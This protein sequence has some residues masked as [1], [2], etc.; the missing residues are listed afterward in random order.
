MID[1][2]THILPSVDDGSQS[3]EMSVAMIKRLEEQGVEKIV[4]TPHFYAAQN[5]VDEFLQKRQ[6]AFLCLK[7]SLIEKPKCEIYMGAEVFYMDSLD[8]AEGFERLCVEGSE[9]LL[10]ELPFEKWSERVFET[11]F[12]ITNREITP[13]IAHF[14]RFLPFGNTFD[15]MRSLRGM[16]CVLQM[17]ANFFDGMFIRRKAV[18]FFKEGIAAVLGSDCHNMTT[19]PPEIK[20][21]YDA[22]EKSLGKDMVR[23]MNQTGEH[24]LRNAR[25]YI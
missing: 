8:K 2:H 16:G 5:S 24:I 1:M 12:R 13:I 15:D 10:L 19:R 21:A 20:S 18:K 9:F 7:N 4:L 25:R 22:L 11:V 6:E 17:N 3:G 23:A 14:E